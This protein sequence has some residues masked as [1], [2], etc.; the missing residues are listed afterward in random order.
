MPRIVPAFKS[1]SIEPPVQQYCIVC[2]TL[3]HNIA[4]IASLFNSALFDGRQRQLLV[5]KVENYRNN[6]NELPNKPISCDKKRVTIYQNLIQ[7]IKYSPDKISGI[8]SH[9]ICSD[10]RQY[11]FYF[12]L[13]VLCL[14]LFAR[15][16]QMQIHPPHVNE[17]DSE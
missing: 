16:M 4:A 5:V 1:D 6:P 17:T 12:N 9:D 7:F 2:F 15:Y 10:F 13:T 11:I 8:F 14:F 3:Y